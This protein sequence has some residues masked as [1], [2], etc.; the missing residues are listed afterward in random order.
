MDSCMKPAL[1]Y[2][3]P[4][5]PAS[6]YLL[7]SVL[8]VAHLQFEPIYDPAT[9]PDGL[10]PTDLFRR[11]NFSLPPHGYALVADTR[12]LTELYANAAPTVLVLSPCSTTPEEEWRLYNGP[13]DLTPLSF[14]VRLALLHALAEEKASLD[15]HCSKEGWF[16][17]DPYSREYSSKLWMIK[18]LRADATGAAYACNGYQSGDIKDLHALV[19]TGLRNILQRLQS[20][21][22]YSTEAAKTGGVFGGLP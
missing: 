21:P 19:S 16:W 22:Q 2:T 14:Y 9:V 1:I 18:T 5:T 4:F 3:A 11:L 6:R 12:T 15:P 20:F 7:E 8:S 10:S 17:V 13:G